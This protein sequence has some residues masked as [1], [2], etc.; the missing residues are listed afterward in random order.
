MT[1]QPL[2]EFL[3]ADFPQY[4]GRLDTLWG[5]IDGIA[6]GLN[7]HLY[8][9]PLQALSVA[10]LIISVFYFPELCILSCVVVIIAT[11]SASSSPSATILRHQNNGASHSPKYV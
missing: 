4:P 3:C 11:G 5:K 9:S 1:P 8:P 10:V 6:F 2:D 7:L